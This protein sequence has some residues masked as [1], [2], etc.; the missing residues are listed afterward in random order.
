[1][2][3]SQGQAF[4]SCYFRGEGL[5]LR[6]EGQEDH[7]VPHRIPQL[8]SMAATLADLAVE[9]TD[10]GELQLAKLLVDAMNE[11][12]QGALALRP[13]PSGTA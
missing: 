7:G 12:K 9:A 1:M 5:H 2:V 4:A 10:M 8:N 6:R 11:A 3:E 13:I